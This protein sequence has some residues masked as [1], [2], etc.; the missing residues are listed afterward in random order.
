MNVGHVEGA[1]GVEPT[2]R[3]D[4]KTRSSAAREARD[5]ADEAH[6]SDVSKE[7]LKLE[8]RVRNEPD[9]RQD[10]VDAARARLESGELDSPAAFNETAER[11]LG[12]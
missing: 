2:P 4:E 1:G 12:Y 3:P 7:A 9:S 10:R 6:I 11:L 8:N 5:T